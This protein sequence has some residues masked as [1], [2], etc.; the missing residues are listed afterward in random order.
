[1]SIPAAEVTPAGWVSVS[2][3]S[4]TASVG[5]SRAWLMPVFTFC[6]STSRTQIVVDSAP[7]PVVVG[8]AT[9]GLS[10]LLRR[11]RLADRGVDVVHQLAVV[12]GEQ[13][14]RLR[15]VDRGPAADRDERVPRPGV[16]GVGDRRLHA[17]VGRL[18]VDAVEDRRLDAELAHL[19]GD[20]LRVAGGGDAR[21]GDH[22]DPADVVLGEVVADLVG[23]ALAELQTG[24]AVGEDRFELMRPNL[25][26]GS[27]AQR[28]GDQPGD[29]RPAR[30]RCRPAGTQATASVVPS[31]S[32][33]ARFPVARPRPRTPGAPPW[34]S[35][36]RP[37]GAVPVKCSS[38][39][40]SSSPT[41]AVRPLSSRDLASDGRSRAL[42]VV[43]P[44]AGQASR[45]PG[46][47]PRAELRVSRT[48]VVAPHQRVRREPLPARRAV[49][50]QRL[51]HH[52]HGRAPCPTRRRPP[53]ASGRRRWTRRPRRPA[54]RARRRAPRRRTRSARSAAPVA[55]LALLPVSSVPVGGADPDGR[56]SSQ[57]RPVSSWTSRTTAASGCSPKSIPPPGSVHCSFSEIDGA[58]RER[59]GR[60]RHAR[61]RRTPPPAGGEAAAVESCRH[62]WESRDR[63]AARYFVRMQDALERPAPTPAPPPAKQ[64][65]PWFDNAKM[66]LIVLVVAR[67]LLDA[68][69]LPRTAW[70]AGPT[71]SSTPGTSRRS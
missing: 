64:R 27:H 63:H 6:A 61:S 70:T 20:P 14:D 56:P 26:A 17:G 41:V 54:A 49:P 1:M 34:K 10:A 21:V 47:G 31:G 25:T 15:G 46:R 53:G 29:R 18:D 35:S 36:S 11:P 50:G 51:A 40:P 43:D 13:V 12:G 42:A 69:A 37:C 33:T 38:C 59:A 30:P 44:A 45:C 32:R 52:R 9:S 5:R 66:A 65:D 2:A 4:T 19:V 68:A 60:R 71:T 3:G 57:L 22:Q 28:S 24:R 39:T 55:E 7:V 67:S 58:R 23:G 8:T 62:G 48:G 16:A